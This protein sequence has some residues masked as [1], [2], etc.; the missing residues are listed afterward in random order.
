M[1]SEFLES[2]LS[3]VSLL[4]SGPVGKGYPPRKPVGPTWS[5]RR[6]QVHDFR[7]G[8]LLLLYWFLYFYLDTS[9]VERRSIQKQPSRCNK[10]SV[11]L[12]LYRGRVACTWHADMRGTLMRLIEISPTWCYKKRATVKEYW[13]LERSQERFHL[14]RT[15]PKILVPLFMCN[16][17]IQPSCVTWRILREFCFCA[18]SVLSSV[19]TPRS[20]E[21]MTPFHTPSEFVFFSPPLIL[22]RSLITTQSTIR[23]GANLQ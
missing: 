2:S 7:F 23:V 12:M 11:A 4:P 8:F 17:Y 13:S 22:L 10:L 6:F 21:Q 15:S 1:N 14:C 20:K 5:R 19:I 16:L 18:L 9:F 3:T